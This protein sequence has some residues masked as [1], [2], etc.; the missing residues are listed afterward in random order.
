M[1]TCRFASESG[2]PWYKCASRI[3]TTS[4]LV[5][6]CCRPP[7][8][9]HMNCE[10]IATMC[11]QCHA[12]TVDHARVGSLVHAVAHAHWEQSPSKVSTQ[13]TALR[14][15][16]PRFLWT[17]V[18]CK[19]GLYQCMLPSGG[20]VQVF[21]VY[22]MQHLMLVGLMLPWYPISTSSTPWQHLDT[23]AVLLSMAGIVI[24]ALADTSLHEFMSSDRKGKPVVLREGLWGISRHPNH[25]GEQLWWWGAAL[26]AV[27]A[28][29]A[30][31]L[32]GTAFNSLCMWK[33]CALQYELHGQLTL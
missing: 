32:M 8:C 13:S 26:F 3:P 7:G 15:P 2:G 30:W 4:Y 19:I 11:I 29:Q 24:A 33:V 9:L 10:R 14:N 17:Q 20:C 22:G 12:T 28:G 31:T 1:P 21:A 25:L 6:I 27:A 16:R 5:L 23:L 18:A